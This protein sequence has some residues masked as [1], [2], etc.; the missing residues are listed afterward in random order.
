[1]KIGLNFILI[2]CSLF[3]LPEEVMAE[4]DY[5][6]G[7][8]RAQY[9]LNGTRP[10]ERDFAIG[11]GDRSSYEQKIRSLINDPN[12]YDAMMRYHERML[13]VGLPLEYI[14]ELL[15]EDIDNKTN[16]FASI[17]CE[18]LGGANGRFRCFWTSNAETDRSGGCPLAWEEAASVFW[19]PG[20]VAWVC[21]SIVK[22][23]GHDLSNCFVNYSDEDEARNSELGTTEVF[24]SRFA[25]IHSLSRQSAGIATAIVIENYPYTKILEPGLTAI[26][27]AIAHFYRQ[28]H[29]FKI[30][31]LQLNEEI[32]E[33]AKNMPLTDVRYR[34]FKTTEYDYASAGV[35]TTFGF[36]RRYDK[37]RTRAN[38]LYER[39][40]CKQFTSE[41]P[42]VFPQ[43]P[44]NLRIA[45]G[46]SDCHS[47]LDPL[48][49]FFLAWGE[50]GDLYIGGSNQVS[51][52][53]SEAGCSGDSVATLGQ[54]LQQNQGFATCQVHHVWEWL[55]GRQFYS[56]E[57]TL[58]AE[59]TK[60]F[61][62][63]N[64]SMKE[65]IFAVATHPAF[66]ERSR[67]DAEVTDPLSEP[68]LGQLPGEQEVVCDQDS[69]SYDADIA[70]LSDQL[71]GSCHGSGTSLELA[72][73]SDWQTW[74]S[75]AIDSMG[76][77][78]MPR[79]SPDWDVVTQFRDKVI[80]WSR[81]S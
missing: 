4:E 58:R 78:R 40:L 2:V 64:F 50:E 45:P 52:Q 79:G 6:F 15:R 72:T 38:Q 17:T 1:M 68:P 62:G 39:L 77:R 41:L 56:S 48:A 47:V 20:I 18:R 23:C 63:T 75:A 66:V 57:D 53:F 19:Y 34:L 46:C 21:P 49:D 74:A 31:G 65:L 35:L 42:A 32:L 33:F 54:C 14:D 12:F 61:I 60:Y 13:G 37:N 36:L 69:Y 26:D 22:A 80:C 8:R 16:K 29:H 30:D 59:L 67:G 11:S 9:L 7:L 43:D 55:M 71:C 44:G 73:E 76:V 27:G 24:D 10:T 3:T 28:N 5:V 25:V 70:S 51:T 81:G